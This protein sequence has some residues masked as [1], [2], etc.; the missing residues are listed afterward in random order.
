[1]LRFN[2]LTVAAWLTVFALAVTGDRPALSAPQQKPQPQAKA[3]HGRG[4][5]RPPPEVRAKLHAEAFRRHGHR[6]RQHVMAM[7]APAT[8]DSRTLGWIP[9]I[10]D[11]GQ[12]GDCYG[13]SSSDALSVAFI[14]A[15]YQKADG[16]FVISE[17]YGLDCGTYDGGCNGGFGQQ[18]YGEMKSK[19][20]PAEK[21]LD[22]GGKSVSD[23]G[24][25]TANPGQCQLKA[26]AKMWQCADWGYVTS[27]QSER[28]PTVAE[29]K[30]GV[31]NYATVTFCF[32]A[33]ALD[34]YNGQPI[35]RLG[36]SIDHEITGFCGWDDNKACPDGSKGAFLCRN[37]W[38]S[39]FGDGGY[40]WLAYTALP[41]VVDAC[42]LTATA[43]P[44]PVPP[45]P[46][47]NPPTPSGPVKSAVITL[48]DGTTQTLIAGTA[49]TKDTTVGQILEM[50]GKGQ[51]VIPGGSPAQGDARWQEQSHVNKV[52][53]DA[54]QSLQKAVDT[55][56]KQLGAAP[57]APAPAKTPA[58]TR[59]PALDLSWLHA[60]TER[61]RADTRQKLAVLKA[62]GE[63]MK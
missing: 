7:T 23:Y 21:Y 22:S 42:F 8:W 61:L 34:S 10:R 3:P 49:I 40:F 30:A 50:M 28:A 59:T 55:L 2:W 17:Q 31:M 43:L 56:H 5:N 52:L 20:F 47:P 16:S 12:C 33:S 36:S 11:Q 18:V 57:K 1:M 24:P 41:A 26:G 13:V 38:G 60:D 6:M 35:T 29:V 32:D 37:Q 44:P 51:A 15:G 25:Y 45:P 63:A 58:P 48:A 54:V 9:P 27:D 46:G 39:Q 19:G 4:Y 53:L 62:V 14:K